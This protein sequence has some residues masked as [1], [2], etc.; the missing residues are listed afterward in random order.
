MIAN[1]KFEIELP[2]KLKLYF[3]DLGRWNTG[4]WR[5]RFGA[6]RESGTPVPHS[7]AF[8]GVN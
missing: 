6:E 8:G 3:A 4:Y 1:C 2:A 5:R 7:K